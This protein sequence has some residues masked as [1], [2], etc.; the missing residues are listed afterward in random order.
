MTL[1]TLL[2]LFLLICG[3]IFVRAGERATNNQASAPPQKTMIQP[4][5]RIRID[6]DTDAVHFIRDNNDPNVVTKAYPMKHADAIE[7]VPYLREMVQAVKNNE[8]SVGVDAIK[9]NDGYSILLISCEED[10][11]EPEL[12]EHGIDRMVAELDKPGFKA[13]TGSAR[14]FYF[15]KYR[16][17]GELAELIYNVGTAH[18][19]DPYELQQ[20]NDIVT[21]DPELNS[22]FFFTTLFSRKNIA[23]AL[24][25][26]DQ[27]LPQIGIEFV[28]YELDEEEDGQIGNDFQTWKNQAGSDLLALGGRFRNNWAAETANGILPQSGSNSTRFLNL[29]PNW[30]TSYLSFLVSTSRAHVMTSGEI[31]VCNNRPAVIDRTTKIFVTENTPM[32]NQ[33]LSSSTTVNGSISSSKSTL[34][35][36]YFI[37]ADS[38]GKAIT[39]NNGSG[40]ITGSCS[41]VK[42]MP[43]GNPAATRYQLAIEGGTLVKQ[44]EYLG[45]QAETASFELYKREVD[46]SGNITWA[47]VDWTDDI[48]IDKGVSQQTIP[49]PEFGLKMTV[50][51]Q[52]CAQSTTLEIQV[53]NS[54]LA[55]W[56]SD[57]TPRI[58]RDSDIT[59][60]VMLDNRGQN[61]VLGGIEK[62]TVVRSTS[63]MPL[64]RELP[65]LGWLFGSESETTQKTHLIVVAKC[66][67]HRPDSP[68]PQEIKQ[69]QIG[70][71]L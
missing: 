37:A 49:S 61:F 20:G 21:T 69:K 71:F 29:G 18:S 31:T 3:G 11:F 13:S 39:I 14:L 1:R 62:S 46:S 38:S 50:T 4:H 7:L 12:G 33:I 10:R 22:L 24:S 65:G 43:P 9:Y 27:P 66:R 32:T 5:I 17:A 34:T 28:V 48:K 2:I 15:P 16:S 58:T 51:P 67:I 54:S 45:R 68:L 53:T 64:L 57:G 60:A 41:A 59:T 25:K 55:G 40:S 47:T 19:E 26:Y 42:M 52:I 8:D 44:G 6:K 36:Y 70:L 35:D 30:N 23:E 63:G 56:Q